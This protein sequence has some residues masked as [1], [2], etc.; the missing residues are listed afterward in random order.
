MKTMHNKKGFTLIELI[1]II[2]ILGILA[3]IAIPK[4][5]DIQEDARQAV[6]AGAL[7]ALAG[8]DNIL[9]ANKIIN[10]GTYDF[11]SVYGSVNPSGWTADAGG[12]Y[13]DNYATSY[14]FTYTANGANSPGQYKKGNW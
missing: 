7:G 9:F 8:A 11:A 1:I 2:V 13:I 4:Y 10:G 14:Q 12:I 5:L 3:A 6:A